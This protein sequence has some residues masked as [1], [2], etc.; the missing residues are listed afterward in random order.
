MSRARLA[1]HV[2]AAQPT[3]GSAAPSRRE[4]RSQA[5]REA[6]VEAALRVMSKRG[7]YL[8]RIE[9]ITEA[10]DVAKGS[11][12]GHFE[13]KDE[14]LAAVIDLIVDEMA[15]HIHD[16]QRGP[17]VAARAKILCTWM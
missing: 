17:S 4:R 14:I 2:M 10:A 3:R 12:Y 15:P 8:T 9:D 1:S 6:L 7:V 5:I 16:A 11:F 13:G